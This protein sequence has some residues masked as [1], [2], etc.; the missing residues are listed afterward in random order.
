MHC[1]GSLTG[2]TCCYVIHAAYAASYVRIVI[3]SLLAEFLRTAQELCL[4]LS[5]TYLGMDF[6]TVS[7][8]VRPSLPRVLQ[9]RLSC[10]LKKKVDS[11]RTLT[12]L[13]DMMESLAPLLPLGRLHKWEFQCHVCFGFSQ[14]SI[15]TLGSLSLRGFAFPPFSG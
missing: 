4:S 9:A 1:F 15:G 7:L 5:F 3:R 8:T 6:D 11:G 2:Y 10:L 13:L 14:R 12:S